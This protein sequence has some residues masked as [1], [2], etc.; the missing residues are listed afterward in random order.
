MPSEPGGVAAG[1]ARPRA[2]AAHPGVD[3]R[4]EGRHR[5]AARPAP[6][7]ARRRRRRRAAA[8][9]LAASIAPGPPPVATDVAAASRRPSRAASAY[10]GVPRSARV[11]A[12]HADERPARAPAVSAW[13]IAWSCSAAPARRRASPRPLRPR[14]GAGVE[15]VG[16]RRGV[17]EL[18]G[19]VEVA[20]S[21]SRARRAGRAAPG[22]PPPRPR[23][24]RRRRKCSRGR[25][26]PPAGNGPAPR[27]AHAG[28][29]P[30]PATPTAPAR[31]AASRRSSSSR[32]S[33]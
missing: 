22:R 8:P 9:R 5:G 28:P 12:H 14:V 26:R 31:P 7:R 20:R 23:R 18:V 21:T 3:R 27:P 2:R 29:P 19:G 24:R 25:P 16:A 13:S 1:V 4:P 6:R 30:A 11:P 10:A 17:V 33:T 15:G 32:D